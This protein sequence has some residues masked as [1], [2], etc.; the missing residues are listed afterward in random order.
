MVTLLNDQTQNHLRSFL[1]AVTIRN[2]YMIPGKIPIVS[3]YSVG[4]S[5]LNAIVNFNYRRMQ[6]RS[7]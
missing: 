7:R 3:I 6:I 2:I 5:K 1:G 4:M